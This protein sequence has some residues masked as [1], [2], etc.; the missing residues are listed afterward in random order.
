MPHWPAYIPVVAER[1]QVAVIVTDDMVR[2]VRTLTA[3]GSSNLWRNEVAPRG[4]LQ[5]MGCHPAKDA[6]RLTAPLLVCVAID[7]F[8]PDQDQLADRA[9]RGWLLRYPGDHF[10]FYNDEQ[11][12]RRVLRRPAGV[13]R[14]ASPTGERA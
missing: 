3:M 2:H 12:I 11:T 9:P 10:A 7:D 14:R 6:V 13:P 4:L 8:A 5:M 1:G